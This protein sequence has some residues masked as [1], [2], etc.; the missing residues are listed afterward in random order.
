[1]VELGRCSGRAIA[2]RSWQ[3]N[4]NDTFWSAAPANAVIR[5]SS[6][7]DNEPGTQVPF[8]KSH[9]MSEGRI[10]I[11]LAETLG[12]DIL[13]TLR[14]ITTDENGRKVLLVSV[15]D[16]TLVH[17]AELSISGTETTEVEVVVQDDGER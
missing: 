9:R 3:S 4:R 6:F 8:T 16:D 5:S 12:T 2:A 11:P 10:D 13:S 14:S 17:S 7:A 1:L 15:S